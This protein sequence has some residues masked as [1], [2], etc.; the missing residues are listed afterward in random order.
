MPTYQKI[1]DAAIPKFRQF[2]DAIGWVEGR[3]F[4]VLKSPFPKVV[5]GRQEIHFLSAQNPERMVAVEY[6]HG[7]LSEAGSTD[8]EAF[9]R[10]RQRTRCPLA[11]CRQI[12]VEGVPEGIN[13]FADEF[14]DQG[15]ADWVEV[16]EREYY[17]AAK[18]FRRFRVRT[19][20]NPF[21]PA[22]YAEILRQE[23][24]HSPAHQASY[25]DG[26]FTP[27]TQ[28]GCYTNY[29]PSSHDVEDL[30]P[31]PHKE[32]LLTWDFNANPLAWISMQ[33]QTVE[34]YEAR[35]SRYVAIHNSDLG[36]ST[37]E[38]AVAEFAAKH[39]AVRFGRTPI[40]LYGDSSGHAQSHKRRETD[41]EAIAF[42]LRQFGFQNVSVRALKYNPQE[43]LS[44]DALNRWFLTGQ[45][46]L[47]KRCTAYRRSLI[48]TRW[49]EGEKK[50]E[51]KP[52][53]THT[54]HSDAAKYAAYAI[55]EFAIKQIHSFNG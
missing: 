30:E 43:T 47:C 7:V 29:K 32:L 4:E 14:D 36:S 53:E 13:W 20:D 18:L 1:H 8:H 28:G 23:Y 27:L 33:A 46:V 3:Q 22:E 5:V 54:H 44:V 51:K 34:S 9:Q 16:A 24:A 48:S 12:L 37:L 50:I 40:S 55:Q 26:I 35:D 11:A 41:Y 49:R 25:I 19:T 6:S 38:D 2:F 45:H 39:P 10:L 15:R 42:Y 52:G 31:S 17:N 21:L